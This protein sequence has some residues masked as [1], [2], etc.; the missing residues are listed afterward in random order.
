MDAPPQ[1]SMAEHRE[2]EGQLESD[3]SA[4]LDDP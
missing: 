1:F 4:D 2:A 3:L